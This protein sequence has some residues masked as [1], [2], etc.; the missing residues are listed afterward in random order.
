M[1]PTPIRFLLVP[2]HCLPNPFITIFL[3]VDV[4]ICAL[5]RLLYQLNNIA[6]LGYGSKGVNTRQNAYLRGCING[7]RL[8]NAWAQMLVYFRSS[9]TE[10]TGKTSSI[11]PE[12]FSFLNYVA[13]IL[14]PKICIGMNYTETEGHMEMGRDILCRSR[15]T[16]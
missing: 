8:G 2:L 14:S 9:V 7:F 13:F 6:Y 12:A 10:N 5:G 1:Y 3:K 4:P 11:A 15:S 16:Q